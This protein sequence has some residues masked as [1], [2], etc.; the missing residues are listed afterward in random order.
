MKDDLFEGL[1]GDAE[2]DPL[3]QAAG[4]VS[5]QQAR[6]SGRKGWQRLC[7]M[8]PREWEL[9]LLD[10]KRVSTYRLAVE[11]LYLHWYGK[12]E[13][14]TV[15]GTVAKSVK[16]STR[17]KSNALAELELLGLI[18]MDRSPRRSPRVALLHVPVK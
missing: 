16:L 18:E 6:K 10:A 3:W 15:S 2:N 17:S 4:R 8:I 5:E 1:F 13:S 14:V 12:G 9:R 7:T 11:L